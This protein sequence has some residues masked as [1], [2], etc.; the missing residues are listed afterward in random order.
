M[1]LR[2]EGTAARGWRSRGKR[3]AMPKPVSQSAPVPALTA[4]VIEQLAG[5]ERVCALAIAGRALS[6]LRQQKLDPVPC[7]LINDRIV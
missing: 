5:E 2:R 4:A 7:L 3:E 1:P 6:M